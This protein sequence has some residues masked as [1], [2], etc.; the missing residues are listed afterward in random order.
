[1][2]GPI[3][4]D[5]NA[6]L[7]LAGIVNNAEDSIDAA[8][9]GKPYSDLVRTLRAGRGPGPGIGK[10]QCHFISTVSGDP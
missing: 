9:C 2:T 3:A 6:R 4:A 5:G 10:R 8:E 7:D 1:M